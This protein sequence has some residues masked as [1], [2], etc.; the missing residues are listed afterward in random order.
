MKKRKSDICT[1]VFDEMGQDVVR[2]RLLRL[3]KKYRIKRCQ[4]EKEI[5]IAHSTL[6]R[7]LTRKN[8]IAFSC[9]CKIVR[10]IVIIEE[11]E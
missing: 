8:N 10:F 6:W 7:F 2:D 5:G 4:M 1:V 3:C 11:G 9:L